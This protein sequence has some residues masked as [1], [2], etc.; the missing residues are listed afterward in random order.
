MEFSRIG[1][2]PRFAEGVKEYSIFA[3]GFSIQ[4]R[5]GILLTDVKIRAEYFL[6]LG[7]GW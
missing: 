1:F 3:A 2:V 4:F 5:I 6:R 7:I